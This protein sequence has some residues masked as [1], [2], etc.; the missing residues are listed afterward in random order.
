M[1]RGHAEYGDTVRD[2]LGYVAIQ[3]SGQDAQKSDLLAIGRQI[4]RHKAK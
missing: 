1:V 3:S 2:S 4:Q